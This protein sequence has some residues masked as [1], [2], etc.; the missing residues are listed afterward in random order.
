M[1]Q[2][3]ENGPKSGP[4]PDPVF[5]PVI[6]TYTRAQAIADGVLV[7]VTSTAYE[8]GFKWPVAVTEAVW[9]D[10][11][12]WSEEDSQRQ[13]HQDQAGRLWDV[14]FMAW[15]AARTNPKATGAVNY[16]IHRVPRD[17]VSQR[18]Q[19]VELKLV[20]SGGDQGEPV[21][22]IMQPHED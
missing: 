8:A 4:T 11:I 15:V 21:L 7:D 12:E 5:G 14:L 17:G 18:S 16:G 2:Q 9:T 6:F 22:T 19:R 20:V 1:S 10:C 13:V 3:A